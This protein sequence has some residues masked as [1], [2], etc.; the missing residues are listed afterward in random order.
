LLSISVVN[1]STLAT[2]QFVVS[3]S[4]MF[5]DARL[6]LD[7]LPICTVRLSEKLLNHKYSPQSK[8]TYWIS[9]LVGGI[10]HHS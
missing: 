10:I 9:H 7:D 6:Q 2:K 3:W 1:Y 5:F 8:V 4:S